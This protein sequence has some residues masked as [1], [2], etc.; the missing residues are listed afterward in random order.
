MP[1]TTVNCFTLLVLPLLGGFPLIVSAATNVTR[2]DVHAATDVY[3]A[4]LNGTNVPHESAVYSTPDGSDVQGLLV[5][6]RTT[7]ATRTAVKAFGHN[8]CARLHRSPCP[9]LCT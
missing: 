9:S 8:P 1:S 5:P 6:T 3:F 7:G 2:A 4:K